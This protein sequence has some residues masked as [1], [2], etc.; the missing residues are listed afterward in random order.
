MKQ[1]E[2]TTARISSLRL[3][4]GFRI[5]KFAEMYNPR[6]IKVASDGTVYISQREPGT[7]VMLR[8]T[9]NDGRADIQK[10]VA[11][12]KSMHGIALR[13]N[14]LY[15]ITIRE[16]YR[17]RRKADGTLSTP[18]LLIK[19]LPDAGQHPNRTIEFGPDGK[20]YI[21]VGS[22][23]NVARE[24]N[25]ENATMLVADADG[26]NRM[27]FASGLRNTIGF[28]WHPLLGRLFG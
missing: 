27:V 21:S 12:R 17:A 18:Q 7:L 14:Y 15:F 1:F 10:I 20:L 26:K 19:D 5:S 22:T 16:L 25:Q 2:P 9:N 13:G 28:G 23:T 6:M 8:D 11:T 24:P 4:A 3:P